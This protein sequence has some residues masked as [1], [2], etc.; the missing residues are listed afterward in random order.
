MIGGKTRPDQKA[1]AIRKVNE[2]Y[3]LKLTDDVAEAILL[4][5]YAVDVLHR[6][7]MRKKLF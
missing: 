4:G 7:E 6:Q 2:M 3:G 1:E 5:K